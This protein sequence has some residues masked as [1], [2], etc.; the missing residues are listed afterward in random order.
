[1]RFKSRA[2][3][4]TGAAALLACAYGCYLGAQAGCSSPDPASLAGAKTWSSAQPDA[5][6]ADFVTVVA[7][8]APSDPRAAPLR[9]AL[10]AHFTAVKGQSGTT[11]KTALQ[12]TFTA[13]CL[14]PSALAVGL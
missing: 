6:V 4:R 10:K 3:S 5:A 11:A 13:A 9:Q 14:A 7:G 12:S 1:M 8:L 2:M